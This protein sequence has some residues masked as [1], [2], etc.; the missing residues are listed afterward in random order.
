LRP[1][2]ALAQV[3]ARKTLFSQIGGHQPRTGVGGENFQ[4]GGENLK[5]RREFSFSLHNKLAQDVANVQGLVIFY[6]P[7]GESLDIFRINLEDT[8]AAHTAKRVTGSVDQS[9][10]RLSESI[11]DWDNTSHVWRRFTGNLDEDVPAK[12]KITKTETRK[13]KVEFRILD[14]SLQ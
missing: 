8:V 4:W 14:F 7:E 9:V 10:Q 11:W 6:S 2:R 1:F 5:G 12:H 13:G 3:D